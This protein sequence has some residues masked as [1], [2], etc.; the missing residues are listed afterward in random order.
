[1]SR[2]F[3][4]CSTSFGWSRGRYPAGALRFLSAQ[5]YL[6]YERRPPCFHHLAYVRI[7]C[8]STYIHVY[9]YTCI[10]YE[11]VSIYIF[12]HT[13]NMHLRGGCRAHTD[14]FRNRVAHDRLN[15]PT[16][17]F[18][19]GIYRSA[20]CF[21][22]IMLLRYIAHVSSFLPCVQISQFRSLPSRGRPNRA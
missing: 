7:V 9:T 12:I 16:H 6:V 5:P 2:I 11:F 13:Y 20:A 22:V 4:L 17:G 8:V 15:L 3:R 1:M 19:I 14:L 21:A 10:L 18:L